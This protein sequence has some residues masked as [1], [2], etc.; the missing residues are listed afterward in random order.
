MSFPRPIVGN[1]RAVHVKARAVLRAL[2]HNAADVTREYK[3]WHI[4]IR[5]GAAYVT[6]WSSAGMVF[7]SL[8][9]VPVFYRPG[10]WEQYLDL[11]FQRGQR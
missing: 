10:P 5:S 9:S 4:E 1:P 3:D 6:V 8:S 2:G 11:L 7:M